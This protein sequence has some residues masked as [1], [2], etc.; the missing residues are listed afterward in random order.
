VKNPVHKSGTFAHGWEGMSVVVVR[1]RFGGVASVGWSG[2]LVVWTRGGRGREEEMKKG[3]ERK[4]K[5]EKG[6]GSGHRG[7]LD[8]SAAR[9]SIPECCLE[10]SAEMIKFAE[11]L[12]AAVL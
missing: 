11:M 2:S 10:M 1:G 9:E 3:R 6:S 7:T 12:D 8:A 4:R 5:E